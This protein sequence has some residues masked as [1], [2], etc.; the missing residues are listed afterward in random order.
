MSSAHSASREEDDLPT[1]P[2]AETRVSAGALRE[3][4]RAAQHS[5]Y[6][7]N[8]RSGWVWAGP[9][10]S[11]L[12]LGPPRS[13]KTSSLVIPNILL[14]DGPV[15]STSTK[16]DVMDATARARSAN[17]WAFLYDP[18]GEIP[19]PRGVERIGW[20]PL[21]TAG[22]WDAAVITAEAM[23]TSSRLHGSRTAEHH[24]TERA[25]A[26][27]STLLHAAALERRSMADL[28]RW[29]DRHD[30]AEALEI[31]DSR[32][33][34]ASPASDLLAGI[35]ATDPRE[36]S[37]IWSTASGVLAAYRTQGALDSTRL[38]SLDLEAFCDGPN[39]LYMCST[40][41]HQR[42]FAP[43]VVAL[44]GDIRDAD[45]RAAGP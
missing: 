6:L 22:H 20:S 18:S 24:W 28:L 41:R 10:S 43:L 3:V 44:V 13:G 26:L 42:H 7:G 38:P 1:A 14:S 4:H 15:V 23:V 11:T 40:G 29:I 37:G 19:C 2:S 8:G 32:R 33:G 27:L 35:V 31:L 25:G 34:G 5:I 39:T 12:V 45:L 30:A 21:S 16:S 17:G 9:Q 36:Q